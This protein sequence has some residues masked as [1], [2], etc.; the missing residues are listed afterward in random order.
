MNF[1]HFFQFCL[2]DFSKIKITS[3]FKMLRSTIPDYSE[4]E[5]KQK[6]YTANKN[7]V[8]CHNI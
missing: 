5:R 7:I 1:A 3:V 6:R 4:E 2:V 8:A